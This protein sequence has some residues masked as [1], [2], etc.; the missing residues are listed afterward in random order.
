MTDKITTCYIKNDGHGY[1]AVEYRGMTE[2]QFAECQN[3]V[4]CTSKTNHPGYM[5][6]DQGKITWMSK[7]LFEN[8]VREKKI[9]L[10]NKTMSGRYI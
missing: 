5:M 8:A 7:V 3:D 2:Q 1:R 9:S 6:I 10:R 4:D